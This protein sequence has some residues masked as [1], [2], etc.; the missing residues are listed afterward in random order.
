M[1]R[2]KVLVTDAMAPEGQEILD[3]YSDL[4][5]IEICKG[6]S[7]DELLKKIADVEALIVRSAT[8]VT[9]K[10][11]ESGKK[12]KLIGRAGIGIDNIDLAAATHHGVI[13]MNTPD[14]NATTTAEHTIALLFAAARRIPRANRSL[15]DGKWD[16][17]SFVGTELSGKVAGLIGL[18]TIGK[19]VADRLMGLKMKVIAYDPFVA[20]EVAQGLGVQMVDKDI[21]FQTADIISLHVPFIEETKNIIDEK[22]FSMMKKGV[23]LINCARGGIVSEKAAQEALENKTLK[24]FATDVFEKE[25]PPPNHP[26]LS[27][28]DVVATPHL[29]A[30]TKEAQ[31]NVSIAVAHQVAAYF[32]S[33]EVKNALNFP[34]L[35]GKAA[36]KMAPYTTLG[37]N[38]GVFLTQWNSLP[39][40]TLEVGYQGEICDLDCRCVTSSVVK[41]FLSRIHAERVNYVNALSLAKKSGLHILETKT[42]EQEDFSSLIRLRIKGP[43]GSTGSFQKFG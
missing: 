21:L 18:G 16:R 34:N 5:D 10:V 43:I 12:L 9:K 2:P 29:G 41:G 32:K 3:S 36:E 25:P 17:K 13:V 26:L 1:S 24:A 40:E 8:K 15:W 35:S 14:E 23:I 33:G 28:P 27:H 42:K 7:P 20:P 4:L 19:I 30:Q 39:T 22:A 6:L 31:R 11:I 37:E 38:L